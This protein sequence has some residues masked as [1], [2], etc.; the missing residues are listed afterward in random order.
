MID[1]TIVG[2]E[3]Q[4]SASSQ[5]QTGTTTEPKQSF[6]DDHNSDIIST[7]EVRADY[8]FI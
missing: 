8:I 1:E 7:D 5:K 2:K 6:S 4:P 3:Q